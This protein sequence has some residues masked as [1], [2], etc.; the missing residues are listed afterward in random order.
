MGSDATIRFPPKTETRI[1]SLFGPLV[2]VAGQPPNSVGPIDCANVF[3][4]EFVG[5]NDCEQVFAIW[6]S[7]GLWSRRSSQHPHGPSD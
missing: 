5:F 3:P 7:L 6:I 2:T 1:R 4:W